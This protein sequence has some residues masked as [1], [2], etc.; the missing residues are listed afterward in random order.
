MGVSPFN[1]NQ[2]FIFAHI[3]IAKIISNNHANVVNE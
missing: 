1:K 2:S 3:I